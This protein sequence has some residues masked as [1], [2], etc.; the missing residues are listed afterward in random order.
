[1]VK[2]PEPVIAVE[3]VP[4]L[5]VK[6]FSAA[7]E[8]AASLKVPIVVFSLTAIPPEPAAVNVVIEVVPPRVRVLVPLELTVVMV[9]F[10]P[11]KVRVV[12]A[13][14]SVVTAAVPPT[15]VLPPDT[16]EEVRAPVKVLEPPEIAPLTAPVKSFVPPEIA[17]VV[18]P[19]TVV[20]PPEIAASKLPVTATVPSVIPLVMVALLP[21]E[22]EPAPDNVET[23]TVPELP[24]KFTVPALDTVPTL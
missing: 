8:I 15:V 22:V 10:A 13:P 14:E 23:V 3:L 17:P 7:T 12:S 19:V 6:I 16:V 21:N 20:A 18:V 5:I 4:E 1:M 9:L 24:L 11:F 2:L